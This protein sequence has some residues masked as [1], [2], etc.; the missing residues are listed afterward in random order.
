MTPEYPG[1]TNA[2]YAATAANGSSAYPYLV[3]P[4]DRGA[5]DTAN[6][7]QGPVPLDPAAIPY[8]GP[9]VSVPRSN[10]V[11]AHSEHA[12]LGQRSGG[13]RVAT[14]DGETLDY[15]AELRGAVDAASGRLTVPELW[16]GFPGRA[17]GGF[18]AAAVLVAASEQT[19]QARPLS[20]FSR[21]YRPAPVGQ[22]LALALAEERRGRNVDT[23]TARLSDGDRLLSTFSVAF[24]CDGDAEFTAQ[25]I[26]PVAPV[27]QPRPVWEHLEA[28][29]IEAGALMRR[30]GYRAETEKLP[31]EELAAGWHMRAEWPAAACED[32][33]V[34]AAVAAMAIDAFVG[35]ATMRANERDLDGDWPVMMPSLDLNCWFYAPEAQRGCDWLT[36]RTSVPVSRAGYAVGRTQV[37]AGDRLT[38]EGMSQVALVAVPPGEGGNA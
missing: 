5:A 33:A 13:R 23:L 8:T 22:P 9:N 26:P 2:Y 38:A 21:Y 15:G 12:T 7:G 18:L 37:W 20:L 29:G 11:P 28:M 10:A 35:P 27:V 34:H 19:R 30:L 17:F 36:V 6:F 14:S 3:G 16:E 24:G 31:A 32:P 1:E 25:A 4:T